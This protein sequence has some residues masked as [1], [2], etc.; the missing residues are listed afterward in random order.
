M[1]GIDYVYHHIGSVDKEANDTLCEYFKRFTEEHKDGEPYSFE[2]FNAG[3]RELNLDENRQ[4]LSG[5]SRAYAIWL[6]TNGYERVRAYSDAGTELWQIVECHDIY[7]ED[8]LKFLDRYFAEAGFGKNHDRSTIL[9]KYKIQC[10]KA[11]KRVPSRNFSIIGACE[12]WAHDRGYKLVIGRGNARS[13][14]M[15]VYGEDEAECKYI[16][17][18]EEQSDISVSNDYEDRLARLGLAV[19]CLSEAMSDVVS[20]K[21]RFSNDLIDMVLEYVDDKLL[22]AFGRVGLHY[23][24]DSK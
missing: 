12:K 16:G 3:L 18:T 21:D 17:A 20:M 19:R 11:H 2:V 4:S 7:T 5:Y 10:K 9:D 15:V 22:K 1:S 13:S 6:S 14:V 24:S 23:E 8:M